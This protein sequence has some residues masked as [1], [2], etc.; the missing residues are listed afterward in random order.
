MS[1]STR[2]LKNTWGASSPWPTIVIGFSSVPRMASSDRMV[3]RSAMMDGALV[4]VSFAFGAAFSVRITSLPSRRPRM[5]SVRDSALPAAVLTAAENTRV[6]ISVLP[7][8]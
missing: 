5:N 2:F 4:S 8:I 3:T 1:L 6:V 7:G